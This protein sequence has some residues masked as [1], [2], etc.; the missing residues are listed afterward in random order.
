MSETC[1]NCYY[2]RS[3]VGGPAYSR[4]CRRHAPRIEPYRSYVT[5]TWP[6]TDEPMW[7][8]EWQPSKAITLIPKGWTVTPGAVV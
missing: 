8:G 1:G 2:W 7:C 4:E 3:S 6:L 5:G